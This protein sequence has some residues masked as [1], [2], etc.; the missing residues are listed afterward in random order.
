MKIKKIRIQ[1]FKVFQNIIIDFEASDLTVFDGPNGF[2]KTSIYDAIELLF[3]GKIRRFDDLRNRLIDGRESFSEH[4]FLCDYADGDISITIEFS[5]GDS[6]YIL[7]RT[8][9]REELINSV[10][11]SI[12]KLCRKN[13]FESQEN[14]RIDNE[15]EYLNPILGHNYK[16]NF[17]FLNYVEQEDSLFL[18]KSQDKNRKQHISHLFNVATFEERIIKIDKL[19]NKISEL[20]ASEKQ[21]EIDT[22]KESIQKNKIFLAN[23]FDNA[24]YIKLFTDKDIFWDLEEFDYQNI[25]YG[26]LFDEEGVITKLKK[27]IQNKDHFE[28]YIRNQKIDKLIRDKDNTENFLLYYHFLPNRDFFQNQKAEIQKINETLKI[29]AEFSIEDLKKDVSFLDL[30]DFDF[31]E[32]NLVNDFEEGYDSILSN[33]D[34]LDKLENIYSKIE[35]SRSKL[36][37]NIKRLKEDEQLDGTCFLCGHD[38]ANF[39][40]LLKSIEIQSLTLEEITSSKSKAFNEELSKFKT[41][42]I[43]PIIEMFNQKTTDNKIDINFV[44]RLLSVDES[45]FRILKKDFD[46]VNFAYS[47]Y[48]NEISSS[49]I[50]IDI[51]NAIIPILSSLKS[52]MEI[53]SIES[54][55]K[56]LFTQY[57]DNQFEFLKSFQIESILKKEKYLKFKYSVLQNEILEKNKQEL[58]NKESKFKNAKSLE[59]N[60]TSLNSIYKKSLKEYQTK[61]I[62]DIEI[63]FHIYSGRIM[64]DFQGGL[65]LFIYSNRGVIRFQS[66]PTKTFDAIFS[67]SSGQLSALIISFTL[68]LHKKYSQNQIILIDDPVQTMDEINI[69]GFVELLRNEFYSNQI[70]VSTHEDMASA[71]MRYKFKNYGLAQKRINL[72]SR[73]RSFN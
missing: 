16:Q 50:I 37:N 42:V 68:A 33:Y 39:E 52:E 22:L 73:S 55:F 5:K 10:D 43:L 65:G 64:Q 9:K 32:D 36:V 69:V 48:L 14:D 21:L 59:K 23:E 45:F 34:E 66:N 35:E 62:E 6:T 40:E 72:K 4:P 26:G 27:L 7:Q 30:T 17:Q 38:W 8:A 44:N 56:E 29:L 11:F 46:S 57:F 12:Y 67:M 20:C 3:T 41:E 13:N 51:E 49:D 60:L 1:N 47:E 63:I 31:I 2:G 71:F 19:K 58:Q 18:L 24:E 53:E 54:Y 70:V 61:V 15:E 25:S 28:K